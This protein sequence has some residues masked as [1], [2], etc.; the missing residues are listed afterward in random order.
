MDDENLLVVRGELDV[1][2][3]LTAYK[4]LDEVEGGYAN[5]PADKGGE[6]I[7]GIARKFHPDWPGWT[8][9]DVLKQAPNFPHIAEVNPELKGAAGVFY[10]QEYW[11][12]LRGD[13]IPQQEIAD[14]LFDTAVNFGLG[15][16]VKFLQESLNEIATT[17]TV[18]GALGQATLSAIKALAGAPSTRL[19]LISRL[20]HRR[21][22]HRVRVCAEDNTQWQFLYGWIKRDLRLT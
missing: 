20:E 6:T 10:R 2:D 1:A 8:L 11:N 5:D 18:D 22:V 16:A 17:L 3:F 9:L 14:Y 4:K 15:Q 19:L 21:L 7:F 13:D 12:R